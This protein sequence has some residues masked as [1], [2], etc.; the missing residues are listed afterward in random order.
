MNKKIL[1]ACLAVG[2]ASAHLVQAQ[3]ASGST[4]QTVAPGWTSEIN[5]DVRYYDWSNS[6]GG[7][8][9]QFY[10]PL[11]AQLSG[12]PNEDLKTDFLIRSG[13]IWSGQ[14]TPTTSTKTS[15]FTDTALSGT[16]TYLGLNGIQPFFSMNINVPTSNVT[17][18]TRS[19]SKP[20]SDVV[21]TP[22]YGEG[23]NFG[24][25]IGTSFA[26]D[27]SLV[28]TLSAGY[29][30]RGSFDQGITS[31][32]GARRLDPGDVTTINGGIGY[33]GDR[34]VAQGS[35]S[36]SAETTTHAGGLPL[37]R[38]GDRVIADLKAGYA[39][40]DNWSSRVAGG[41][42][43]FAKNEV[44]VQA[45]VP[46]LVREAFNSNSN[47]SRVSLDTSYS[48]GNYTIG[49]ALSYLYR[50][51]N[52]YDPVTYQF[53]PAK[54]SWSIGLIG[55][56]ATSDRISISARAERIRVDEKSNP[57]KADLFN[58]IIPGSGMPESSTDAWVIS[59][60]ASV[61]F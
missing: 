19:T 58:T 12:R 43:H 56:V 54:R 4:A 21:A 52:G 1:A 60:G 24:P 42:S 39:W 7:K 49:P 35:L 61:Q 26:I 20:D 3:T 31:T 44:P 6:V 14:S 46:A 15:G 40:N 10:V 11:A 28:A 50:D 36:Y 16:I 32:S 41:Y 37:Y 17:G 48:A 18:Q 23:W 30:N 22:V 29:I 55:Q 25:S 2:A 9:Y 34:V 53:V 5:G 45:G 57:D 59:I 38:S 8:G 13:Q 51:H 27:P 33:R 47:V